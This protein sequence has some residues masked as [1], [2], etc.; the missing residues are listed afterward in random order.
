M[1]G[2]L[3]PEKKEGLKK[4]TNR[5]DPFNFGQKELDIRCVEVYADSVHNLLEGKEWLK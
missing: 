2:L 3:S 4:K 5:C 1:T